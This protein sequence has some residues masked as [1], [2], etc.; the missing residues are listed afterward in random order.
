MSK[1]TVKLNKDHQIAMAQ[2]SIRLMPANYQIARREH[3][4]WHMDADPAIPLSLVLLVTTLLQDHATK[5][6][7]PDILF[8]KVQTA[9]S[10]GFVHEWMCAETAAEAFCSWAGLES[11]L[12]E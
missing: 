3:N 8:S 6:G 7:Q 4:C 9:M 5:W 2:N 1:I 12:G 11:N 10:R